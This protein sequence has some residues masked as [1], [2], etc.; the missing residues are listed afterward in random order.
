M[1]SVNEGT[2][3]AGRSSNSLILHEVKKYFNLPTYQEKDTVYGYHFFRLLQRAEQVHLL[4]NTDSNTALAEKSRFLKQLDFEVKAQGL[5]NIHIHELVLPTHVNTEK[6]SNEI[7]IGK[8]EAIIKQLKEKQYSYSHLND[9]LNCP[10]QFYLKHIAHIEPADDISES[11]EQKLI[12]DAIHHLMDKIGQELIA[13]PAAYPQII[14]DTLK[15]ID[16]QVEAAMKEA[17]LGDR[18]QGTGIRGQGSGVRDQVEGRRWKVEGDLPQE[19]GVRGQGTGVSDLETVRGIQNSSLIPLLLEGVAEGRGSDAN[20]IQNSKYRIQ[21]TNEPE[22]VN[23][24]LSTVNPK[25]HIDLT[26]G[27]SYLA[28]EVVKKAVIAYLKSMKADFEKAEK[29]QYSFKIIAT[30]QKMTCTINVDQNPI[31]LKG[32]ADRIDFRNGL[33][34]LLDYKTGFVNDKGLSYEKFDD[35]FTGTEHKQL[36]QLLMYAYLYERS[37]RTGT[38]DQESVIRGQGSG[39]SEQGADVGM[40]NAQW[41]MHNAQCTMHNAQCTMHNGQCTMHNG[42]CTMHNAQCTMYNAQCTMKTVCQLKPVS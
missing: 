13:Q 30:E 9:Y 16:S 4:Y 11:V 33:V 15:N 12:G 40:H 28:T 8:N 1:L 42:Q 29:Q 22:T 5:G 24:Q 2:L 35:I 31:Q 41:T 27:K 20:I 32:Y 34:T 14:E 3:P 6:S 39:D 10:L 25:I 38:S 19:S 36:L 37:Q 7:S 17:I 26:H 21:N 23:C 18:G